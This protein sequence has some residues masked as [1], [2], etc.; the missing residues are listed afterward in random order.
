MLVMEKTSAAHEGGLAESGGLKVV[1]RACWR[2]ELLE[3]EELVVTEPR[4]CCELVGMGNFELL[5]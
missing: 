1:M 5:A 4:W 3:E 2:R